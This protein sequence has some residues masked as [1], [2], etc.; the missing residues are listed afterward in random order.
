[1]GQMT[2]GYGEARRVVELLN[3][4]CDCSVTSIGEAIDTMWPATLTPIKLLPLVFTVHC[5]VFDFRYA[6]QIVNGLN[7]ELPPQY[8]LVIDYELP[9]S[10]WYVSD[11][12]GKLVGSKGVV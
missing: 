5:S 4:D 3:V 9:R 7:H 11:G 10:A 8:N 12:M 1:M 2:L 6:R